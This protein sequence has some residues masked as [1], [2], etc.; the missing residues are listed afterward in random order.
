MTPAVLRNVGGAENHVFV[1]HTHTTTTKI[2]WASTIIYFGSS[3]HVSQ[4]VQVQAPQGGGT[5]VRVRT[6]TFRYVRPSFYPTKPQ[7]FNKKHHAAGD[8]WPVIDQPTDSLAP[9]RPTSGALFPLALAFETTARCSRRLPSASRRSF[10]LRKAPTRVRSASG[11][12][13]SSPSHCP[14][15]CRRGRR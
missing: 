13:P 4:R 7:L 15:R 3:I 9:I 12:S 5:R 6:G 2:G 11:R 14:R 8:K 10:S 1:R